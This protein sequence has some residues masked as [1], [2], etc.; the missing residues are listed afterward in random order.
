[1][2]TQYDGISMCS[3]SKFIYVG[4]MRIH[5]ET[6]ALPCFLTVGGYAHGKLGITRIKACIFS[7]L[8]CTPNLSGRVF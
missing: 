7:N 8:E 4:D 5:E 1:M 3:Q 2:N 6:Q